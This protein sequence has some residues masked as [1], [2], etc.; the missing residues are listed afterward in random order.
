MTM[1]RLF[2]ID[3]GLSF[4]LALTGVLVLSS[5]LAAQGRGRGNPPFGLPPGPPNFHDRAG[6]PPGPPFIPPGLGGDNPGRGHGNAGG[7]PGLRGPEAEPVI[8]GIPGRLLMG[9]LTVAEVLDFPEAHGQSRRCDRR[10]NRSRET[11]IGD[12]ELAQR[13]GD[14]RVIGSR[15]REG[16]AGE[17]EAELL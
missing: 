15:V 4:G 8:D 6:F 12:A 1:R 9:I 14:G 7:P 10:L 13:A 5:P 17:V 3:L 2:R 11:A 16:L